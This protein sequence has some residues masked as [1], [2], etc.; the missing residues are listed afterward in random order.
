MKKILVVAHDAGAAQLYASY[1]FYKKIKF[2]A[3]LTG[4]AKKVFDLYNFQFIN[5]NKLKL[6]KII[7][8]YDFI[9]TSS[10]WQTN[11]EK[12]AFLLANRNNIKIISISII[13]ILR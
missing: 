1:F 13:Y 9:F 11:L 6:K 5:F 3:I 4:P 7:T 8:N 12:N 10:G 2:D